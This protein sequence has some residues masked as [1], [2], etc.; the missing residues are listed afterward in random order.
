M[1]YVNLSYYVGK[2]PKQVSGPKFFWVS[3]RGPQSR[4]AGIFGTLKSEFFNFHL[5][6]GHQNKRHHKDT[7][8]SFYLQKKRGKLAKNWISY[9]HF[10]AVTWIFLKICISAFLQKKLIWARGHNFGTDMVYN[11]DLPQLPWEK[12]QNGLTKQNSVTQSS[13]GQWVDLIIKLKRWFFIIVINFRHN[14]QFIRA[15]KFHQYCYFFYKQLIKQDFIASKSFISVMDFNHGYEISSAEK[16]IWVNIYLR[17]TLP[18]SA[19]APASTPAWGWGGYIPAS[20]GRPSRQA[21]R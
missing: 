5:D 2:T 10:S 20:P 1:G 14:N 15:M 21:C 8:F 17:C 18:S 3:S 9:G 6:L 7:G 12:Y 11:I 16:K 4:V 13:L 19:Q